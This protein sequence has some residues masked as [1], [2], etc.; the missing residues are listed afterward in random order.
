VHSQPR[1]AVERSGFL[2]KIG[3]ENVLASFDEAI[4][5]AEHLIAKGL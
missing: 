1:F 3:K 4:Q 2:E 5:R